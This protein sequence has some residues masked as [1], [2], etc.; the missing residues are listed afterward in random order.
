MTTNNVIH[1]SIPQP[2]NGILN[3]VPRKDIIKIPTGFVHIVIKINLLNFIFVKPAT[4]HK[5]S[6][7]KNGNRNAI[8]RKN[9]AFLFNKFVYFVMFFS[10]NIHETNL[11]PNVLPIKNAI[12]EPT[13]TP[14]VQN[15][16]Q[17]NGP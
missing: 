12:L 8:A 7:G 5:I 1:I 9:V 3:P 17:S 6:S 14:I 16:K 15:I 2:L 13:T 4:I 10:P 11:I